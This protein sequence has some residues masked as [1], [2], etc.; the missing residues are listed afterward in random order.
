VIVR[1]AGARIL[2]GLVG[3]VAIPK[4]TAG[5]SVYW[6]A[7]D[8]TGPTESEPTFGTVSLS[9]KC[10]GTFS[11][12]TRSMLLQSTPAI[13]ELVRQDLAASV[14]LG[15][16]LGALHGTGA[17]NQ[18]TGVAAT[19]GIGSVAGGTNGLAPT[20]SHIIDL[21]TEVAV[22]NA[23]LGN[24]AYI[25][26]AKVRGKLQKTAVESGDALRVWDRHSPGTPLNGY[27]AHVTNQVSSA[28]DKGTSTG[29]CSGIFFGNWADMIIGMWGALD[30]L[31]DPFTFSAAG[32]LRVRALQDV[33]IAVRHAESFAAMLDALTA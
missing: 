6:V 24:L 31:A 22:D 2:D 12:M 13:E 8:L 4:K 33:D 11:D 28:L 10:V 26:N 19:S 27:K 29:V 32:G 30:I 5:A 1:Q 7:E 18:P 21:E 15:I 25:T 23:D 20:E 16:D 9:P 14:A 3:N 17:N